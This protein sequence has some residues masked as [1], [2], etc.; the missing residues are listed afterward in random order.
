MGYRLYVHGSFQT[1]CIFPL[2]YLYL[3]QLITLYM[4]YNKEMLLVTWQTEGLLMPTKLCQEIDPSFEPLLTDCFCWHSCIYYFLIPISITAIVTLHICVIIKLSE[5]YSQSQ[6]NYL[7]HHI[8]HVQ[9]FNVGH[10]HLSLSLLNKRT[11]GGPSI[12]SL[13]YSL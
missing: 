13:L 3:V 6:S 5:Y 9:F 8:R 7:E 1:A 12:K 10:I 11:Q 4:Q 2:S